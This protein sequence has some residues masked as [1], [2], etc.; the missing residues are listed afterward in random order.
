MLGLV[1]VRMAQDL[2]LDVSAGGPYTISVR[3]PFSYLQ[4]NPP[5]PKR[6]LVRNPLL[7]SLSAVL[8]TPNLRAGQ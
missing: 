4:W 1:A 7:P 5:R 8:S 3:S 2:S 6:T